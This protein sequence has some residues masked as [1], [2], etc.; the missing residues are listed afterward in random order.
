M[1]KRQRSLTHQV[2]AQRRVVA[3]AGAGSWLAAS[4]HFDDPQCRATGRHSPSQLRCAVQ[5]LG[6]AR[7]PQMGRGVP[8]GSARASRKPADGLPGLWTR[9][10]P[11]RPALDGLWRSSLRLLGPCWV[12]GCKGRDACLIQ[13]ASL[14]AP[15]STLAGGR[16][17]MGWDAPRPDAPRRLRRVAEGKD[18]AAWRRD[19]SRAQPRAATR[20]PGFGPSM[21]STARTHPLPIAS[22][23]APT[24]VVHR[25]ELSTAEK[26]K[27]FLSSDSGLHNL[28]IL[29]I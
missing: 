18:G 28:L 11:T 5:R 10:N 15:C 25:A 8:D 19:R 12:K 27:F 24:Q 4:A 1:W 21:A 23:V 13:P 9:G 2:T 16:A 3:R 14:S 29:I 20:R 17:S 7:C 26:F 6:A 22:T